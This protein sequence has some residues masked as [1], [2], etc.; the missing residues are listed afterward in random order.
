MSA[1][2][3]STQATNSPRS[4]G[5]LGSRTLWIDTPP[6][7]SSAGDSS[8]PRVSTWTS[9][10]SSTRAS[11][12][13]RT[14][15]ARPPSINGGYSQERMRTE[16]TAGTICRLSGLQ[17]GS[18]AEVWC[19]V[20][21]AGIRGIGLRRTTRDGVMPAGVYG[22]EQRTRVTCRALERIVT[23]LLAP[24]EKR[25]VAGLEREE[26]ARRSF[27]RLWREL[28]RADGIDEPQLQPPRR[29]GHVPHGWR[30]PGAQ[31]LLLAPGGLSES[32]G[33]RLMPIEGRRQRNEPDPALGSFAQDGRQPE[34]PLRPPMTQELCVDREREQAGASALGAKASEPGRHPVEEFRGMLPGA[35][36]R[37]SRSVGAS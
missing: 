10:S 27:G 28:A 29:P 22:L 3:R 1:F 2:I 9:V 20:S 18:E 30:I 17:Q 12:S 34:W 37:R 16:V 13:F 26:L 36:R 11:D 25:P 14:W 4:V 8:P 19:Q 21:H 7:I 31:V 33:L 24:V 6:T 15:R 5:R 35:I 32:A 23:R